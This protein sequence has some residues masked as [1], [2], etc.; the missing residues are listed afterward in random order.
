[1][2]R[3]I[4]SA[5]AVL[6][7][8]APAFADNVQAPG[9]VNETAAKIHAQLQLQD[10]DFNKGLSQYIGVQ[11]NNASAATLSSRSAS[12][13]RAAEIFE[14]MALEDNSRNNGLPAR[15]TQTAFSGEVVNARAAAIF[16][17]LDLADDAD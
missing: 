7:F 13:T 3:I 6:S 8:A 5:A 12:S 17:A 14:Q 15:G 2:N 11:G 1:M 9:Y 16:E 4:L 10:D